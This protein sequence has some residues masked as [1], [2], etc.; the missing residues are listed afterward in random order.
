MNRKLLLASVAISGLMSAQD[1]L[2]YVDEISAVQVENGVKFV[3][4]LEDN[5]YYDPSEL[6]CI[7][8]YNPLAERDTFIVSSKYPT[9]HL[10]DETQWEEGEALIEGTEVPAWQK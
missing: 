6:N 8:D 9:C 3:I 4:T 10:I 2:P 1:N 7:G 5:E